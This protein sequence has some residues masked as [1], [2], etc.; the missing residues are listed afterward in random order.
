[1]LSVPFHLEQILWLNDERS[2]DFLIDLLPPADQDPR[3]SR[4]LRFRD[5]IWMT[6]RMVDEHNKVRQSGLGALSLLNHLEAG[7]LVVNKNEQ[8]SRSYYQERR[9]DPAF[10]G[11]MLRAIHKTIAQIHQGH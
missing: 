1:M 6:K 2:I 10:R 7:H 5:L 3:K 9:N 8:R 11:M 4:S